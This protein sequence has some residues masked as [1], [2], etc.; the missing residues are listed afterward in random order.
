MI[1]AHVQGLRKPNVTLS[2]ARSL[3]R[4]GEVEGAI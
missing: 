2:G 3:R 1:L 4:A